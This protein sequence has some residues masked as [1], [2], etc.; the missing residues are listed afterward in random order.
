MR[1]LAAL[2]FY[3][4]VWGLVVETVDRLMGDPFDPLDVLTMAVQIC[5]AIL[6]WPLFRRLWGARRE[7]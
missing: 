6:L 3:V 5:L 4:L 2:L 7:R 1:T